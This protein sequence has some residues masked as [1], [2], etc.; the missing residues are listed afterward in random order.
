MGTLRPHR[1]AHRA[2]RR[3]RLSAAE[4]RDRPTAFPATVSE[5]HRAR[6]L[7]EARRVRR[8]SPPPIA[9][10]MAAA[11]HAVGLDGFAARPLDTLSG[12]QMQRALF[13]RVMLQD[14]PVVLLD[15]PFTAID[16]QHRA[17][18]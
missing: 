11:L 16:E 8:A 12:G 9:S 2:G 15:E 17:A 14:A 13:A 7:A 3:D 18:T 4:R 6:P 10:S 1:R 5:L